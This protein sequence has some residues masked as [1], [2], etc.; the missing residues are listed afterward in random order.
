MVHFW[1]IQRINKAPKLYSLLIWEREKKKLR[2]WLCFV[3]K[4]VI[5]YPAN[6]FYP[7]P[8][9]LSTLHCLVIKTWLWENCRKV[10]S[11]F[12]FVWLEF[13]Q[14]LRPI[15]TLQNNRRFGVYC[16][17]SFFAVPVTWSTAAWYCSALKM[18]VTMS[19]ILDKIKFGLLE[20][21]F[22]EKKHFD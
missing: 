13:W 12:R 5:F 19:C 20:W 16:V 18:S 9:W 8:W 17:L 15:K 1:N 22:S 14:G 6:D 2:C 3:S 7:W 21:Y 4:L 11:W 10:L